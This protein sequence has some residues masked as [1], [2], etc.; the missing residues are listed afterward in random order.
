MG[1]NLDNVWGYWSTQ[2]PLYYLM[3]QLAW[4]PRQDGTAV[5]DDYFRRGFGPAAADV[6]AYWELLEQA[7]RQMDERKAAWRE[8]FD[9]ALFARAQALLQQGRTQLGEDHQRHAARLDFV[10]AGLDFLRLQTENR[11]LIARLRET[12]NEDADALVQARTNWERIEQIARQYP[13]ALNLN[14]VS[15]NVSGG[16]LKSI[17]PDLYDK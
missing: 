7:R 15:R 1:I 10:M 9:V 4:N 16:P 11:E 12:R 5:L 17:H 8:A 2:G 3:A 14:H 6:K 13:L